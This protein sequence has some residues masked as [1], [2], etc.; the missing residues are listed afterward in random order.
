MKGIQSFLEFI[1]KNWTT[2]VVCLGLLIGIVK[3]VQDFFSK[4]DEERIEIVKKE[5]Q[6]TM[7]KMISDAEANYADWNKAGEIKRSQV[8][9]EIY[10]RYPILSK[11]INQEEMVAWI[12]SEIDNSLKTLREIIKINSAEKTEQK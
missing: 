11:A 8:I 7:L 5:I 2:I 4:T 12:D 10:E 3:K 1:N 9:K 6:Q